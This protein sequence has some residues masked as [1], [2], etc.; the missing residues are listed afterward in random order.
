MPPQIHEHTGVRL[1]RARK[2]RKL[3]QRELSELSHVSYS[4]VTKVEQGVMAASPQVI[5]ALARALSV[6]TTDLTGQPYLEELRKDQLDGLIEPIR[7]ALDVYDLGPDP[8]ITPRPLNMLTTASEKLCALV[9]ATNIKQ[10]A[11]SLPSLIQETTTAAHSNPSD[12]AWRTLASMYR[13]AYD[14]ATKLG[15]V[16][17]CMV[18]LDRMEWAAQRAS[19]PLLSSMRQ[20]MR[21]L[22]HL[23]LGQ[24]GTGSRLIR[25]GLSTADQAGAC[26]ERNVVTGQLHLGGAVIAARAQD[27][28][29]ANGYLAEAERLA[30]ITGPAE[31]VHWL[32]F[33]PTN[34]KVHRVS[35]LT[36]LDQYPEAVRSADKLKLPEA[37]PKSRVAH[38][39]AEVARALLWSGQTKAAFGELQEAR[40]IAPQQ[41][42]YNP[43][44][45]ETMTALSAARRA[46]PNSFSNFAA[47]IGM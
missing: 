41:T 36:E 43:Q 23:R 32:S 9:R 11:S 44:V 17:L 7:Q 28:D 47:W 26:R 16:D 12:D 34:V 13:T 37:W 8:D 38:H 25:L 35:V 24:Y 27:E 29:A 22:S 46:V 3:T 30:K 2:D 40:R 4:T 15:Y 42:R 45:R 10:A 21:A 6:P 1:A 31:R 19:D 33:G 5:G 14:V 18:A 20:Y 39:H